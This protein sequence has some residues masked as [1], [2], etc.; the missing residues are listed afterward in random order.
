ML[1]V[2]FCLVKSYHFGIGRGLLVRCFFLLL[3]VIIMSAC[4]SNQEQLSNAA[5]QVS[6]VS[7][8]T[9]T[10]QTSAQ[11]PTKVATLV[12]NQNSTAFASLPQKSVTP[13]GW[14]FRWLKA[15]PCAPPCWEGVTPGQTTAKEALHILEQSPLTSAVKMGTSPLNVE[16]GLVDWQWLDKS[17]YRIGSSNSGGTAIYSTVKNKD[18]IYLIVPFLP[19]FKF[20]EVIQAYGEPTHI[21][22]SFTT[23]HQP[24]PTDESNFAFV[25][26]IYFIY[27]DKGFIL[28]T[29]SA[30]IP[31]I[32]PN[33]VVEG[34]EFF[35]PAITSLS[36]L[37]YPVNINTLAVPWQ[38][39]KDYRFY[40]RH[41]NGPQRIAEDCSKVPTIGFS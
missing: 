2:I 39:F 24:T 12:S 30:T 33:L 28:D 27:K 32:S 20:G 17:Y 25:Y 37:K 7:T 23:E 10:N 40:C 18:I 16:Q 4:N 6:S 19:S 22:A 15:I 1:S 13:Q 11:I 38:G 5:K 34:V 31:T 36:D 41:A 9:T 29:K 21:V 35:S 8:A 26:R 14:Q 3:T